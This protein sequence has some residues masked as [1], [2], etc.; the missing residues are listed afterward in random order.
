MN[1]LK[2]YQ[3]QKRRNPFLMYLVRNWNKRM[4]PIDPVARTLS[5]YYNLL[6]L[7]CFSVAFVMSVALQINTTGMFLASVG[8]F[9]VVIRVLKDL[10]DWGNFY[11]FYSMLKKIDVMVWKQLK[12]GDVWSGA[13]GISE[14]ICVYCI[15]KTHQERANTILKWKKNS[16]LAPYVKLAWGD[17][18]YSVDMVR[19]IFPTAATKKE[20]VRAA[21]H[22]T[23]PDGVLLPEPSSGGKAHR[24]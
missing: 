17:L 4:S 24:R 14:E 6:R 11:P 13:V 2:L 16:F 7:V 5:S 10:N 21:H 12:D 1:I 3:L 20:T 22:P 18:F 19:R 8:L 15:D 23:T 9:M